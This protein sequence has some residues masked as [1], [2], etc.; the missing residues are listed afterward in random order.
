MT[1]YF[2]TLQ[3]MKKILLIPT[4]VM[5]LI[6]LNFHAQCGGNITAAAKP[7]SIGIVIYSNDTETVWN[8]MRF[9][10]SPQ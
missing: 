9:A 10:N 8:A 7:T 4:V 6:A 5:N 3:T 2:T 1:Y